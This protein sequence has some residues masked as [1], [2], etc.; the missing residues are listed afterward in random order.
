MSRRAQAQERHAPDP[1]AERPHIVVED[2][3]FLR[4]F[5]VILDP[6][7]SPQIVTAFADFMA[8]DEPDFIGWCERLRAAVAPSGLWPARVTIV[9]T[10]QEL[11]AALAQA[12]IAVV[13]GMPFGT[14]ELSAASRLR[15]VQK[16]GSLTRGVDTEACAARGVGV[17]TIRRRANLACAEHAFALMLGLARKIRSYGNVLSPSALAERGHTLRPYGR[18]WTPNGNWARIPG[19]VS[20]H[21][22]TIGIIGLGEIGREIAQRARAFEMRVVYHQRT[23]LPAADEEALGATW[24][25]LDDLLEQSDWV[26]PQLPAS[27]QTRHLLNSERLARMKPGAAIVNVSRPDVMDR[28]AVL[29][30][31]RSGRLGGLGLDPPYESPGRDDD[32][33]TALENVIVTPHFAGSP[34]QNALDDFDEMLRGMA[35]AI[36]R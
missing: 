7:T 27:P 34:R 2:D 11:Q 33:L 4:L 36:A 13:E 6:D 18:R 30:A 26:L 5:P 31:L 16:Y 15:L 20:L 19:L 29:A 23:R 10:T 8:H 9:E 28:E 22:S 3:P 17:L 35:A 1:H 24:L 14:A 25:A 32:E 21:G 12:T